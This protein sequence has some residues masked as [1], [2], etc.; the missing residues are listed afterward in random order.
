MEIQNNR[1]ER[2]TFVLSSVIMIIIFI[3]SGARFFFIQG[4]NNN[5]DIQ[6]LIDLNNIVRPLRPF[7]NKKNTVFFY[8]ESEK[9]KNEL[10]FYLAIAI[11]MAFLISI[12]FAVRCLTKKNSRQLPQQ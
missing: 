10:L 2:T 1:I 4:E 7:T 5:Q 11:I 9:I 3:T 6:K 12:M 8:Q